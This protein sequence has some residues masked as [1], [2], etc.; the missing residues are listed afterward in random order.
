[1]AKVSEKLLD[2]LKNA[3]KHEIA[4]VELDKRLVR[5]GVLGLGVRT[6]DVV[7]ELKR[8]SKVEYDR[9]RDVVTLVAK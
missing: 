4:F 6:S 5:D 1:M 7:Y 2:V 8:E 9:D 3:P